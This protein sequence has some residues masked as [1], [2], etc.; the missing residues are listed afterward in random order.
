MGEP[1]AM[2]LR[3]LRDHA[4]GTKAAELTAGLAGEPADVSGSVRAVDQASDVAVAKAGR[5]EF[6]S[7]DGLKEGEVVG[8][9]EAQSALV[10]R[11]I[12]D[13]PRTV[14]KILAQ[15]VV[16]STGGEGVQ[17][18]VVGALGQL[19]TAMKVSDALA[20][21]GAIQACLAGRRVRPEDLEVA[22]LSDGGLHP[23][24]TAGFV[25]H[26]DGVSATPRQDPDAVIP[27]VRI[28][29]GGQGQP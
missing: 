19:G 14:S 25:V 3:D 17:V 23:E 27:H 12:D 16:S 7:G 20:Q 6:A 22:C 18:G 29:G 28:C 11:A 1:V 15:G 2:G 21:G 26:L 13:G 9:A 4:V 5:G 24:Q 10:P 8:I